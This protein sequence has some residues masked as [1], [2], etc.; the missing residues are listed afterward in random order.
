MDN[1]KHIREAVSALDVWRLYGSTPMGKG[2][3]VN[4]IH[5]SDR[6]PSMKLYDKNRGYYCFS[7]GEGG[8]VIKL[9]ATLLGLKPLDAL[10]QL[11]NV[12]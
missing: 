3:Y 4:C 1:F 12:Y 10:A 2:G 11:S 6:R 7:C 9:T 5:H 8:D